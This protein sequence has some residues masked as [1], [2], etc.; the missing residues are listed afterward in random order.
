MMNIWFQQI[1]FVAETTCVAGHKRNKMGYVNCIL[2]LVSLRQM[3]CF[4]ETE[5]FD[6]SAGYYYY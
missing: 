3:V 5:L 1:Y 4:I 2:S 6:G